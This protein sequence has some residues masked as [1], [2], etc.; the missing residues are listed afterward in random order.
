MTVIETI[1]YSALS[2]GTYNYLISKMD[3]ST[4]EGRI[5]CG[6]AS[7]AVSTAVCFPI[8]TIRR[9]KIVRPTEPVWA[10]FYSL[11]ADTGPKRLYRGLSIALIKSIP[12]VA[13]TLTANDFLLSK[14][15]AVNR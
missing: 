3:T 6:F 15:N 2:L 12:T 4:I 5:L 8:D 9:N 13:I 14:F 7:G 10:I 11:I 1:P